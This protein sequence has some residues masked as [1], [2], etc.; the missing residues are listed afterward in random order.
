[1]VRLFLTF[2]VLMTGTSARAAINEFEN[3]LLTVKVFIDVPG[4]NLDFKSRETGR[5]IRWKPNTR[6]NVGIGASLAGIIGGSVSAKGSLTQEDRLARG[7]TDYQDWRFFLNYSWVQ[8]LLN[9]QEYRGFYIENSGQIDSAYE[10]SVNSIQARDMSL[11]NYS[12]NTTFVFS[13]SSFSLPAALDQ[14]V[15]QEESG[16]SFLAGLAVN[17]NIFGNDTGL[18]PATVASEFGSDQNI[19]KGTFS[20]LTTKF[21]YGYSWIFG[22]KKWF[23]SGMLQLG[24]GWQNSKYSDAN[25][26]YTTSRPAGKGD[27]ITSF[28]YN[29]DDYFWGL[30]ALADATSYETEHLTITSALYVLSLFVGTRF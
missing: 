24:A 23:L 20:T 29:G 12:V 7:E 3:R 8:V 30:S 27:F 4:M 25:R 17:H 15:R 28:G 5:L 2:L 11:R 22:Q 21:G 14:T 16:G 6:A 26:E 10:N 18:I 1:M 13:P 19:R 9:Y